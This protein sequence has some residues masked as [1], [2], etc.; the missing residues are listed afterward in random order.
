[1]VFTYNYPSSCSVNFF[2][3]I[4]II[5]PEII[6]SIQR[7][8]CHSKKAYHKILTKYNAYFGSFRQLRHAYS[9]SKH[10]SYKVVSKIDFKCVNL[11]R[12]HI[13]CANF[14]Q[15]DTNAESTVQRLTSKLQ[16]MHNAKE[17]SRILKLLCPSFIDNTIRIAH[18]NTQAHN[19]TRSQVQ[20]YKF[21]SLNFL[22][23]LPS[24]L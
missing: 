23:R 3:H 2:N 19:P 8:Q 10:L 1:M 22:T 7:K 9:R 24:I 20:I 18:I 11:Y 4:S 17:Q 13:R 14:E 6:F 5:F 15:E 12:D 21:T 16:N